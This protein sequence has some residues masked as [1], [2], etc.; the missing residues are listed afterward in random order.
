M[1]TC[2]NLFTKQQTP[3]AAL[4]QFSSFLF[5]LRDQ[6]E[7]GPTQVFGRIPDLIQ[8]QTERVAALINVAPGTF[9]AAR[10][11]RQAELG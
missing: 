9:P 4:L 10:R 7:Q 6:L 8:L 3:L 5:D 2:T 11:F 1:N